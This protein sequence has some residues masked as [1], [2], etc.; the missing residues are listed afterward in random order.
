MGATGKI[1]RGIWYVAMAGRR[2]K[3]RNTIG[4]TLLGEP[5]LFGRRVDG[6]VF[7]IRDLCPHRGIPLR[8][9]TFDGETV[10][11]AY[12]G[13]RFG[14]DGRCVEIPALLPDHGVALERIRCPAYPCVEQQGLIWI[15]MAEDGCEPDAEPGRPPVFPDFTASVAPNADVRLIYECGFED[16]AFG[17]IDPAHI[18]FVHTAW[19]L[20]RRDAHTFKT[21]EKHFVPCER[22]WKTAEHDAPDQGFPLSLLGSGMK[23]DIQTWLPGLRVERIFNDRLNISEPTRDHADRR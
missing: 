5:I 2:L 20:R 18:P 22:G 4:R 6:S 7:A 23:T 17:L 15:F 21:K 3:A 11:C 16:A 8:H 13:W 19:W 14:G 9:G 10:Q 12:H 1:L